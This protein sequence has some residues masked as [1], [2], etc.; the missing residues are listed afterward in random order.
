MVR[1]GVSSEF[2]FVIGTFVIRIC[3]VLR[4]SDFGFKSLRQ[5]SC[6]L[7]GGF[8]RNPAQREE[9]SL[10][11]RRLARNRAAAIA[12]SDWRIVAGSEEGKTGGSQLLTARNNPS[13]VGIPDRQS[14]VGFWTI[15]IIYC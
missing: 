3:F 2:V 11:I 10:K 4:A 6:P 12:I 15:R 8:L 5:W 14:V 9:R 7:P 13:A 1:L